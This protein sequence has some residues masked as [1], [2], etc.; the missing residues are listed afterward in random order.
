MGKPFLYSI[1]KKKEFRNIGPVSESWLN[2]VGIFTMK[3]L[4]K[5]GAEKAYK[6]IQD[7]GHHPTINLLYALIGAIY[8]EDWKVVADTMKKKKQKKP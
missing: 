4:D 7:A 8:D 2:D 6:M 5:V 3:E 1:L